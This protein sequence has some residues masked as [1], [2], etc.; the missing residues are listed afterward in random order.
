MKRIILL[1][2]II[3]ATINAQSELVIKCKIRTYD[4]KTPINS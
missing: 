3:F 2:V 4:N 1:F